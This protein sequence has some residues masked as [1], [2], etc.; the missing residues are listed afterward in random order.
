MQRRGFTQTEAA[1][2]LGFDVSFVSHLVNGKR[3]PGLTNA[4]VLQRKAGI[5][6]D[7]WADDEDL[8]PDG[9][10]ANGRNRLIGKK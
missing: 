4:L 10:R 1:E 5:A 3:S 2:Y 7:S 8:L 6:V 9:V